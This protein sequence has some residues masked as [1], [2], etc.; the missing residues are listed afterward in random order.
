[1]AFPPNTVPPTIRAYV[2]GNPV[3]PTDAFVIDRIGVGTMFVTGLGGFGRD[4]LISGL[5]STIVSGVAGNLYWPSPVT[6]ASVTLTSNETGSIVID[7]WKIPRAGLP[8]NSGN[9]IV[10]SAPPTISSGYQSQDT[11]LIGWTKAINAGDVTVF[12][13]R[14]VSSFTEIT[15]TLSFAFS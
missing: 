1:M 10:A 15:I 7:I 8:A 13:V 11:T 14:S 12:N 5:G 3:Q 4:F 9:T 2:D 6:L